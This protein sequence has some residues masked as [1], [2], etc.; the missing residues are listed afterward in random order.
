ME[1]DPITAGPV[2][3]N[4]S[5]IFTEEVPKYGRVSMLF[6]IPDSMKDRETIVDLIIQ[7][8]GNIAKFHES[9]TYQL[10]T[11]DDIDQSEYYCGPV[12]SIRWIVESVEKNALMDKAYY[13]L[14]N[15]NTGLDF[16]YQK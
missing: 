2:S 15:L 11:P 13:S 5:L 16:P 6:Y 12:Y 10:G 14:Y 8:G 7:N 9:F 3:S 1:P 4:Q